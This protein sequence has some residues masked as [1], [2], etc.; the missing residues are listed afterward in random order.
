MDI[1]SGGVVIKDNKVLLLKKRGN[2]WVLPKGHIEKGESLRQAAIREVKEETGIDVVIISKIGWIFYNFYFKKSKHRKKVIWFTMKEI[3]GSLK[4]LKK[5]GFI[6]AKY[7]E[8]K[9]L[10]NINMHENELEIIYKAAF[11]EI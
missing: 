6:D 10:V 11:G 7:I 4:P 2:I 1:S 8:L 9:D 3:G 5:E